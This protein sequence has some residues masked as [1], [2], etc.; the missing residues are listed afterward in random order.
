VT[1]TSVLLPIAAGPPRCGGVLWAASQP[2]CPPNISG[3][4]RQF[5]EI[6]HGAPTDRMPGQVKP[7][8]HGRR[9]SAILIGMEKPEVVTAEEWESARA[10]LLKAE[11]EATRTLDAIAAR[12]R[13]LPMVRFGEYTF[14]APGGSKSLLDLFEGRDQLAVYQFM[15][16]GP[17][18]VCRGCT[19]FTDNVTGHALSM[20]AD[21]GIS[22]AD[23]SNMPLA[24]IEDHKASRGWT[25][26]FVSSR[27]T[28]FA[29]DCGADGGFMFTMFIRN[30]DEVY[31]TYNST[32]R[33]VDRLLFTN[34][35]KDLSVYGRQEDWEDSPPGW[36]QRPTYG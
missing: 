6:S 26:P 10:E 34:N 4:A 9:R 24:Q 1:P 22:W 18:R 29:D 16:V 25:M 35:I 2:H 33:G 7:G 20:L 13:R 23:V 21:N 19:A 30:G 36:P 8:L 17:D 31:R 28:S 11:K 32:Q 27:G 5:D 14:D 3:F 12:R 15:D